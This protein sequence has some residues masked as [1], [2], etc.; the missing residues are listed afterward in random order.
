MW[1]WITFVALMSA[2][3]AARIGLLGVP[4]VVLVYSS[5]LGVRVLAERRLSER[6]ASR[7]GTATF[8][9]ATV[10]LIWYLRIFGA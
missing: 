1:L 9:V 2:I 7:I 10:A 4:L 3:A 8:W 5:V 6:V